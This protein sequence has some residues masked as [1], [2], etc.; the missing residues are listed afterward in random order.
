MVLLSGVPTEPTMSTHPRQ[1]RAVDLH[2]L[3]TEGDVANLAR[4]GPNFR[5]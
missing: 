3:S 1:D 4:K 5:I 2:L